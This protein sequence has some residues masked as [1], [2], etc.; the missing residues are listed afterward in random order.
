MIIR[1]YEYKKLKMKMK[2]AQSDLKEK[3]E[4]SMQELQKKIDIRNQVLQDEFDNYIN[5]VDENAST[6]TSV[7]KQSSFFSKKKKNHLTN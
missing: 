2:N 1:Q 4:L 6:M 5:D 7:R 3:E